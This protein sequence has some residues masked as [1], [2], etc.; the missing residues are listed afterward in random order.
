MTEDIPLI[1]SRIHRNDP[2]FDRSV[3]NLIVELNS[4]DGKSLV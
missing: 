2:S 4:D 3:E 1:S